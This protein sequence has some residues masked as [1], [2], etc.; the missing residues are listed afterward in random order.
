[1][2]PYRYDLMG[3]VEIDVSQEQAEK[4]LSE[5]FVRNPVSGTLDKYREVF[6]DSEEVDLEFE[7]DKETVAK[8]SEYLVSRSFLVEYLE[9]VSRPVSVH[10]YVS[11][12]DVR[13]AYEASVPERVPTYGYEVAYPEDESY[14]VSY[15]EPDGSGAVSK[16]FG[17]FRRMLGIRK[18]ERGVGTSRLS[19]LRRWAAE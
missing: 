12:D 11:R 8:T 17:F 1:M 14:D 19:M 10:R 5:G 4:L 7:E 6:E 2:K 9:T 16:F 3:G 18:K 13:V 15:V